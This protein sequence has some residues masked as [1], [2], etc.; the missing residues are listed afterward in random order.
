MK[1]VLLCQEIHPDGLKLLQGKVEVVVSPDRGE[2]TVRSIIKDFHGVIVR[3]ATQI[4]PE[5][6]KAAARL[7]VIARTGS[8]VDNVDVKTATARGIPVCYAPD[9]NYT[10]VAEH[11][12]ALILALAKQLPVMD[13]AVRDQRFKIR[14]DYLPV[15]VS[16]K[17]V[18]IVGLGKI[19]LE[20]ARRCIQGLNMK[21]MAC[22]PYLVPE[23]VDS[24]IECVDSLESLFA[25]ADFITIHAPHTEKT[26]HMVS[27]GLIRKMR[28]SA[29]LINTSRGAIVDEAALVQALNE[30]KIA[31]AGLDVFEEEP[32]APDNP[33]L[34][35]ENVILTPHSAALTKQCVS[36]MATD[37]V[38]GVLAVLEGHKP[39]YVFNPEALKNSDNTSRGD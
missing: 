12:L 11:T 5:T 26:R 31:G 28:S 27:R 17:T 16:Q 23:Q 37:A 4:G 38:T 24:Q 19:G 29:F 8:G 13:K 36:R 6:I 2:E 15:D 3:T 32:P 35:L 7:E 20:V 9:A 22:D 14:Y 1:R 10:S 33:L 30:K 18:G 21:V 34:A 39:K 25:R